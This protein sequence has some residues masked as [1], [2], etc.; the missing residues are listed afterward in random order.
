MTTTWPRPRAGEEAGAAS[1]G[2]LT[3]MAEIRALP[4]EPPRVGKKRLSRVEEEWPLR[5]ALLVEE[6][7]S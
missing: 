1:G 2:A 7:A 6:R 5:A 4:R 3:A